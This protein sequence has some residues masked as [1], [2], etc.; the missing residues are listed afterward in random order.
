MT[1]S[2]TAQ[3]LYPNLSPPVFEWGFG[4]IWAI[5]LLVGGVA[6]FVFAALLVSSW[7]K[8]RR[9][10]HA[11]RLDVLE[12]ALDHP[13]MD[14][15]TRS[16]VVQLLAREHGDRPLGSL[17]RASFWMSA[18]FIVGWLILIVFGLMALLVRVELLVGVSIQG[19]LVMTAAGL[20]LVTLPIATREFFDR[21]RKE[22][23]VP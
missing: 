4:A 19:P 9:A 16:Q 1:A 6:L 12:K 21:A 23:E 10:R 11:K 3:E 5:L 13:E 20:A 7:L 22:P 2:T 17:A 15:A 8:A 18:S 14:A